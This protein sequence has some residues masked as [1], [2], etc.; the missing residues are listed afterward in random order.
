VGLVLRV[1]RAERGDRGRVPVGSGRHD[2]GRPVDPE[3]GQ[4]LPPLGP[5]VDEEH[6]IRPSQHVS[7]ARKR[8][9]VAGGLG[10]LVERRQD[11]VAENHVADRHRARQT[12]RVDRDEDGASSLRQEPPLRLAKHFRIMHRSGMR[13]A[14]I[15][16][17][18]VWP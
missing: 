8:E 5:A 13:L 7:D 1:F 6:H 11:G 3:P 18:P 17:A 16:A 15:L 9:R 14:W 10:L 4:L 2:R 12:G